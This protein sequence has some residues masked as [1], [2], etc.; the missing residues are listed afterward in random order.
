MNEE[1]KYICVANCPELDLDGVMHCKCM[2]PE[3]RI[4]EYPHSNGCPCGN[5]PM[6]VGMEE[7]Q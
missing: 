6:W 7:F 5:T 3:T 4:E 1:Y 2:N